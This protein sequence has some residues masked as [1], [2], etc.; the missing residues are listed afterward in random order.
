MQKKLEE[1]YGKRGAK[2]ITDVVG[3]DDVK[4]LEL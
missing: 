1:M 4:I 3:G 2:R